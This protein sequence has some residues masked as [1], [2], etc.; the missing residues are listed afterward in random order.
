MGRWGGVGPSVAA[1]G[2][3]RFVIYKA[4]YLLFGWAS[5]RIEGRFCQ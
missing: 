4:G 3:G 2:F 5:R 1:Y